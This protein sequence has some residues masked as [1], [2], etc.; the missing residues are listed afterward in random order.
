MFRSRAAS[1]WSNA[2]SKPSVEE[3]KLARRPFQTRAWLRWSHYNDRLEDPSFACILAHFP[4]AVSNLT[5][6]RTK[7]ADGSSI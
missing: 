1:R 3:L 5:H 7:G 2:G 4:S 6:V